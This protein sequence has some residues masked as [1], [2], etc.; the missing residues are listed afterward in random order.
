MFTLV[1]SL[2]LGL[3]SAKANC[4]VAEHSRSTQGISKQT[5]LLRVFVLL[6]D[7]PQDEILQVAW[8]RNAADMN[9]ASYELATLASYKSDSSDRVA[10]LA[11]LNMSTMR[12]RDEATMNIV[13]ATSMDQAH[14]KALLTALGAEKDS[15]ESLVIVNGV[16][17][18][19]P[20]GQ[21][22]QI[23]SVLKQDPAIAAVLLSRQPLG[24]SSGGIGRAAE[25]LVQ[26]NGSSTAGASI[27]I[28]DS[29]INRNHL[30]FT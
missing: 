22:Q 5:G 24:T 10:A 8:Q 2:Y 4:I 14:V 29:G 9:A 27:A 11:K 16:E 1:L 12:F 20:C 19:V 7:Q 30:L 21:A 26:E 17:A 23:I 28:L 6:K 3:S 25:P 13:Q 15:V 18:S